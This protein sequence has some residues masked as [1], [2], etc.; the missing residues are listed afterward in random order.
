MDWFSDRYFGIAAFAGYEQ[1]E[2]LGGYYTFHGVARLLGDVPP[3]PLGVYEEY[4]EL[5]N[6]LITNIYTMFRGLISDFGLA[7]SLIAGAIWGGI[8]AAAFFALLTRSF[9]AIGAVVY[10]YSVGLIYQSYVIS[11]LT[12]ISI[13]ASA[14]VSLVLFAW[15]RT[16]SLRRHAAELHGELRVIDG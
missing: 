15:I 8:S 6:V 16:T 3:V 14:F 7:G 11:S 5:P 13:P 1:P 12:W 10:I 9:S 4:F 2:L